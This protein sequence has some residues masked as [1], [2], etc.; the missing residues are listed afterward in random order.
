MGN[1][2]QL[3]L[4]VTRPS[5]GRRQ[6]SPPPSLPI[7]R[8]TPTSTKPFMPAAY[9]P[10][11][12]RSKTFAVRQSHPAASSGATE[13]SRMTALQSAGAGMRDRLQMGQRHHHRIH[14]SLEARG[15]FGKRRRP[16][17]DRGASLRRRTPVRVVA[18]SS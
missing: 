16:S 3:P 6:T 18:G 4:P 13:S 10:L 7:A 12:P 14:R 2:Y 1:R 5:A 11:H 8:K 17:R 9:C 15:G